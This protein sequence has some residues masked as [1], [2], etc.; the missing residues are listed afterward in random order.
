VRID[1][2]ELIDFTNDL[3]RAIPKAEPTVKKAVKLTA[4]E[5]QRDWRSNARKVAPRRGVHFPA[6]ITIETE[7]TTG[8]LIGP[9]RDKPQGFL[10][11]ILEYGAV[12]SAPHNLMKDAVDKNE[13]RFSKGV[14]DAIYAELRRTVR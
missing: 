14:L 2:S 9:E 7:G 5:I 6:S 4:I 8:A 3:R 10:G 11:A 12:Y 13:R 1:N